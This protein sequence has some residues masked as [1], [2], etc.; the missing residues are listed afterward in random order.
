V[1]GGLLLAI[2]DRF[3]EHRDKKHKN[4]FLPVAT[5]T[6]NADGALLNGSWYQ[7]HHPSKWC[8]QQLLLARLCRHHAPWRPR[9]KASNFCNTGCA[10]TYISQPASM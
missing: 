10:I 9:G 8:R 1:P 2:P 4:V 5:I 3:Q 6:E 7:H